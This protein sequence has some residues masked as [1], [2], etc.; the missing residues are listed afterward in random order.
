MV[1]LYN[2]MNTIPDKEIIQSSWKSEGIIDAFHNRI[3]GAESLN[4]FHDIEPM[5]EQS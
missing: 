2:Q 1:E 5:M 4:P 3:D